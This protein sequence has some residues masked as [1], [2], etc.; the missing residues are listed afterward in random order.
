MRALD[1][2]QIRGPGL[3]VAL[4]PIP[5]ILLEL[6]RGRMI[7]LVD[8][9]HRENEGDLV[10]AAEKCTPEAIN[11]M[12]GEGRGLV[13]LALT[14]E[15]TSALALPQMVQE[16][17]ARFGTAFTVSVDAACGVTTGISAADRAR[18]ILTAVGDDCKPSD[19]VRPGHV[20][21]LRARAG[22]VL[23]RSGQTEGAV[24]LARLS[25]LAP[26]GVICEVMNEDGSMA[27]M[28]DLERFAIKWGIKIC[29][30][31][32]L[33]K[34]R[35]QREKL[36]ECVESVS[37]PTEYGEF[38]MYLYRTTIGPEHHVALVAGDVEP[39]KPQGS[40]VLVRVHSECLTGDVFGSRRCDCGGQL[41]VALETIGREGK[42]VLLYMRQEGRGIGLPNKV[43]AYALQESGRDTVEAN[44]ELGFPDDLRD[45]GV[46]A[47][48]LVD[49][50][51]REIR[52]LTNNPRKIVGLSGYGLDVV[53]RVPIEVDPCAQNIHYLKT[54]KD[55]LGHM[56]RQL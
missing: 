42:G 44:L 12:A 47:Q 48:I 16:N 27:R 19:L 13:C 49:L 51:L 31:A 50:G 9:E 6:S 36:V 40:P 22:G 23:E 54:K 30:I 7:V 25:G 10:L 8:D 2:R 38:K 11:F 21:P 3:A 35:R 43:R 32:D 46:G 39:G 26:A 53:E 55:K 1:A 20:F 56:L 14:P 28:G 17:T 41:R 15:K 45:Y 18:T 5:E 33:I 4:S 24:D 37:L 34:Y 29:A 52:L